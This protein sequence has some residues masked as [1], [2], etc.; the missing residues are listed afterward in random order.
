MSSEKIK[1]P[2]PDAIPTVFGWALAKTGEVLVSKRGLPNPVEG[3]VP[4][5]PY[6]VKQTAQ[7]INDEEPKPQSVKPAKVKKAKEAPTAQ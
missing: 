6:I 3:F 2:H 1:K 7:K 5:R 4:N